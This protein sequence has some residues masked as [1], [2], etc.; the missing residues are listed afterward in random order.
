MGNVIAV[1]GEI[2]SDQ[3][4]VT[5]AHEHLHCDLS[6]HSGN[7]DNILTDI[8][9]AIS[10]LDFFRKAGGATIL[11]M[12]PVDVGRNPLALEEISRKS[13]VTVVSGIAF[14]SEE[15][16]PDWVHRASID[17]LADYF[18]REIEEGTGGVRAGF[19][20]ELASHNETEPEPNAYRLTEGETQ[21]FQAAA[22]AQRRTGAAIYTHA[23]LGRGGPAQLDVLER[24]G[25][26]IGKVVIG[27]C[28]THWHEDIGKDVA[29]YSE[30]LRRGAC[31]GF[32][33]IGW[34]ELM[35]DEKRAERLAALL[36]TEPAA[37]VVLGTDT[38]RRSQL[39]KN[40]GRG[41]DYLWRSFLPLLRR[42]GIAGDQMNRL[43]IDLPRLIFSVP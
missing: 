17:D 35:P 14:Y 12:T 4:G 43:L 23:S 13:G 36:E 37:R 27:H 11:E 9:A 30:I 34:S 41:L 1:T 3:L 2:T 19:I 39:R 24:A 20:G 10:E 33:L 15:T 42:Y 7:A 26:D 22:K 40:G 32:D 25:T 31:C 38:C 6:I 18:V 16:Y 8:D 29:Y 5:L 21:L 28:D